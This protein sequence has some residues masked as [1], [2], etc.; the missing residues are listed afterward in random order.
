MVPCFFNKY[1]RNSLETVATSLCFAKSTRAKDVLNVARTTYSIES[2]RALFDLLG[3]RIVFHGHSC[4]SCRDSTETR[5]RAKIYPYDD[6][7]QNGNS[8]ALNHHPSQ[9]TSSAGC[10]VIRICRHVAAHGTTWPNRLWTR[11]RRS[12]SF[13]WQSPQAKRHSCKDQVGLG[14]IGRKA[15]H[16]LLSFL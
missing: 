3:F 7:N 10:T 1:C 13:A 11:E 2:R 4:Q 6:G 16:W 15:S 8:S 5:Q 9:T 12:Y 14:S